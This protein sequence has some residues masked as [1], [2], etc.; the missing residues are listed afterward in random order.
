MYFLP[1]LSRYVKSYGY[2][3]QIL[4]FFMMPAHQIMSC[5]VPKKQI[6]KKFYLVLILQLISGKVTKFP[7]EKL[8]TSEVINRKPYRRWKTPP[9]AFRVK[10]AYLKAINLP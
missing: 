1:N 4:A 2:F 6:S 5:H 7:V 9:S 8:S 10:L 3:C